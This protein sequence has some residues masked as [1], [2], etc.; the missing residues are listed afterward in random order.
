MCGKPYRQG[1]AEYGCGQCMPCRFNKRRLW[2][3]RLVMESLVHEHSC[4]ATL[5][6]K[7]APISVSVRDTQLFNKRLR[8]RGVEFRYYTS[9][10]YGDQ[11][12]RPHYHAMLFGIAEQLG[13]H[14]ENC[15]CLICSAWSLGRVH[16]GQVEPE[17]CSY[18]VSYSVKGMTSGKDLRLQGRMPE[19][20]RMSL[21]PGIGANSLQNLASFL[22]SK[23]GAAYISRTGDVPST[24]RFNQK[25]W[26]LGRYL[27]TK[28]R[29]A[30]GMEPNRPEALSRQLTE[31]A[32]ILTLGDEWW[33]YLDKRNSKRQAVVAK[34][35]A[36]HQIA[37][38]KKG[39]GV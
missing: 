15:K 33:D 2:T 12:Q 31:E 14:K 5:T 19:F 6:Y 8:R 10:E 21:R 23:A 27:R 24:I 13:H 35:A 34:A 32:R 29:L 3:S 1:A 38:S 16:V 39:I 4:F 7:D 37:N 26:P 28:L 36:L 20:A 18:V 30:I 17:S 9:G 11:T 22:V 25:I